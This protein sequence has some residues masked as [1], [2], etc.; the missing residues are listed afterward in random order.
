[1]ITSDTI[2]LQ[3]PQAPSAQDHSRPPH[4]P[5]PHGGGPSPHQADAL[6]HAE[7]EAADEQQRSPR[8]S[9][10]HD[11]MQLDG[12]APEDAGTAGIL[13][14]HGA[15][16]APSTLDDSAAGHDGG[17]GDSPAEEGEMADA[18]EEDGEDDDLMDKIS[19]SPS[20]DDGGYHPSF[21][22]PVEAVSPSA[23]LASTPSCSSSSSCPPSYR[24]RSPSPF[25][26]ARSPQPSVSHQHQEEDTSRGHRR[27]RH[28][29]RYD[30]HPHHLPAGGHS[31]GLGNLGNVDHDSVMVDL[32]DRQMSGGSAQPKARNDEGIGEEENGIQTSPGD[33]DLAGLEDLLLPRYDPL[34]D[35][36]PQIREPALPVLSTAPILSTPMRP[37]PAVPVEDG[38][39]DHEDD[40]DD[41]AR[42]KA[43]DDSLPTVPRF[44]DSGLGGECLQDAEDINFDFV[45]ALHGFPATVDGQANASKG[46]TMVLLDDRNSYWWLVRI[47]KDSSIGEFPSAGRRPSVGSFSRAEGTGGPPQDISRPSISRRRRNAWLG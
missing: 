33:L 19:S 36:I 37:V 23:T 27:H 3:D 41:D 24:S 18:D 10:G 45:Y 28:L 6:R 12:H 15:A 5:N 1:M 47:V 35:G 43:D 20:I 14:S 16:D 4:R 29:H 34:L 17:H 13:A 44:A 9:W 11:E 31:R 42:K 39:V 25:V 30:L 21:V 7:E 8:V 38:D 32:N 22:W 46:D 2:D 40:D 26:I